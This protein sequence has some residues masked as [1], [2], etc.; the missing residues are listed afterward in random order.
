MKRGIVTVLGLLGGDA[1]DAL[2]Q[3]LVEGDPGR[4]E[5]AR[6]ALP[7]IAASLSN[8]LA[9]PKTHPDLTSVA[10]V[11]L[12][13]LAANLGYPSLNQLVTEYQAL[14]PQAEPPETAKPR[15][16]RRVKRY[17]TFLHMDTSLNYFRA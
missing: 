6:Q 8:L 14:P 3:Q 1:V 16:V 15:H 2:I 12:H 7:R 17:L 4:Q 13:E 9:L 11:I 5:C 10:Q